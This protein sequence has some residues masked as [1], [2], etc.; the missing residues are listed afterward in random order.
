MVQALLVSD[1]SPESF[2]LA[3]VAEDDVFDTFVLM[4]NQAEGQ[5]QPRELVLGGMERSTVITDLTESTEYNVEI[6]GLT[7]G[8]RSKS[9]LE[10]ARTGTW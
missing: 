1:I 2:R 4:V 8:R 9:V 10:G 6:F 7:L 5:G 3:W